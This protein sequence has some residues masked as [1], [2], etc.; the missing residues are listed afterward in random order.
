MCN[1]TNALMATIG[2][3]DVLWDGKLFPEIVDAEFFD[4]CNLR[5]WVDLPERMFPGQMSIIKQQDDRVEA[6][7]VLKGVLAAQVGIYPGAAPLFPKNMD[8][9]LYDCPQ[10][11]VLEDIECNNPPQNWPSSASLK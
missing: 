5:G 10:P 9:E 11:L 8:A 4:G 7:T 2:E 6:L 3:Y 1:A